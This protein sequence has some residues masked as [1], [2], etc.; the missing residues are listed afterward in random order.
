MIYPHNFEQK[1]GFYKLRNLLKD[2]C[3]GSLGESKV[4]EMKFSTDLAH[5][6]T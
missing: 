1:T 5:I 3:L 6:R 4:E 2:K